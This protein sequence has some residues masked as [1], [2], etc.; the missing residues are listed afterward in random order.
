MVIAHA[1]LPP[2][3]YSVLQRSSA[4]NSAVDRDTMSDLLAVFV[5]SHR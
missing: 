4:L 5:F 3:M 2:G 1:E